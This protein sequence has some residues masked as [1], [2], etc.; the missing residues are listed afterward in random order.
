MLTDFA[1]DSRRAPS[2]GSTMDSAADL[3]LDLTY[4]AGPAAY[5]LPGEVREAKPDRLTS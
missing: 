4:P 3:M 1:T 2:T 5:W